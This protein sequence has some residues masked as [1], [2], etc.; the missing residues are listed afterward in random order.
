MM[1]ISD[2]FLKDSK[3]IRSLSQI[4][5]RILNYIL[6][7]HLLFYKIYNETKSFDIYLPKKMSWIQVISECWRMIKYELNKLGINSIDLF[8]NYIFP[9]LFSALNKHKSIN[10]YNELDEFEKTLDILIQDKISSFIKNYKS[11]S[12]SINSQFSFQDFLEE[13]YED[14]DNNEYP[15]YN[16]FYYSDYINEAY[17]FNQIKSKKDK[18]PVLFKVLENNANNSNINQYSLDHLPNY[19][20]VLNLF[21]ETYFYSIKREKANNLQLKDLKDDEIYLNNRNEIKTFMNFY[22]NLKL[23]DSKNQDMKLSDQSLLADFFIDDNNEFGKSYKKIY[24]EFIKE[25][26]A[27]I[28]NLLDIKIEQDVF[29]RDCKDKIN[30]QSANSNEVFITTFSEKFSF[31][32]VIF[33]SSYRKIALDR[34][35]TSYNQFEVDLN[36]IEDD[37]TVKLLKN[38]KLFNDSIINF[39]YSN[40]KLEFENKNIITEFNQLYN[41]EK[42]NFKN[43]LI[44]YKFYQDN[45]EKNQD[46]FL[47]ILNDF[48]QLIII[49]NNNKKLLNEKN[50]NKAINLKDDSR[51][52]EVLEKSTK[53]SEEFKKLFKDNESLIINKTTYL[54]EYYRDII[55]PRIKNELKAFQINLETEQEEKINNYFKKKTIINEKIFKAAIRAFIVLYLNFEKYIENNIKQNENNIINYLNIIDIWDITTYSKENF[56]EELNNL[57]QLKI[58]MNQIISLYDFLVDDI[59]IKYFEDVQKELDKEKES[60]NIIE[61]EKV[62]VEETSENLP[63]NKEEDEESSYY[64]D[65]EESEESEDPDAK[66]I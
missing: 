65:K 28:T 34:N 35:Y 13:K 44:L 38:K 46:F 30:I 8:M 66:Y 25:Q 9:D 31:D 53:V 41:I 42:L 5:Y 43:K 3:I 10:E 63:D 19:N 22:N 40:E 23:K 59:N 12:K 62:L 24:N 60:K 54:F 1:R 32:E 56:K 27:E 15:F 57:K 21:N 18:Y 33:N 11:L 48:N 45:K 36:L 49:L 37:M 51:I 2:F 6:Y 52:S 64:N 39:V 26:N 17:L 29:E 20:E 4:S 16:Y 14:Y 50:I 58:K 47:T 61:K 7:S 55:F